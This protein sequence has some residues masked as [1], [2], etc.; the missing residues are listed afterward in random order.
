MNQT[1]AKL[2]ETI[3]IKNASLSTCFATKLN[4]SLIKGAKVHP[5]FLVEA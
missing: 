3:D 4:L 5:L 1:I 2:W